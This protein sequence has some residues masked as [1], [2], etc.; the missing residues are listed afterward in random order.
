MFCEISSLV[1]KKNAFKIGAVPVSSGVFSSR[2]SFRKRE[3]WLGNLPSL[4]LL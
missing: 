2:I 4:D 3:K 1:A